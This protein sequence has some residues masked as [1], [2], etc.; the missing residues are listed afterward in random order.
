MRDASPLSRFSDRV[1]DYVRYRPSYP[2]ALLQFLAQKTGLGAASTVADVGAGTGI[3]TSQLLE[4]GAKVWAVEP[5]PEMRA[6]AE[7]QLGARDRFVSQ[8]GSADA[9]GLPDRSISHITCAQAF[10]WFDPV[11]AG[12]E[13]RRILIPAGWCA[14]IWNSNLPEAS[15]FDAGYERIKNEFGTDFK[16]INHQARPKERFHVLFGSAPWQKHSFPNF[17]TFD[18]DGLQGR[19]L[20]S[21]YAPKPGQPGHAPMLAALAELFAR[22]QRDGQVRME[23]ETELFLGQLTRQP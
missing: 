8:T 5:N 12:R 10:H 18:S 17:Q 4:T 6:A 14:L 13:F 15:E 11:T 16:E 9:T 1:A 19:L 2:P 21:S 23:Y 20:S 3:F 22:C 7:A